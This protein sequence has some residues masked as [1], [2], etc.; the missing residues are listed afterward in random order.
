MSKIISASYSL[1]LLLLGPVAFVLGLGPWI[2]RQFPVVD[3]FVV[4]SVDCDGG[5]LKIDGWLEKQRDCKLVEVYAR[6]VVPNELPRVMEV[7]FLDR[8]NS[9]LI[10]RPVGSQTWGP[11]RVKLSKPEGVVELYATHICHPFWETKSQLT[12]INVPTS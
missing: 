5:C 4:T 2:D 8:E 10:T 6:H 3:P 1:W 12:G 11:W 9:Q 7:Q